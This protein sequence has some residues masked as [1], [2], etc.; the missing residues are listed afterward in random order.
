ML[1]TRIFTS[2]DAA[3]NYYAQGDYYGTESQGTWAGKGSKEL[4]LEGEF[5]AKSNSQFSDL[6]KG[7]MPNGQI[8]AKKTKD[9]EIH[10]PGI[11][12]TFSVPK[13]F[14]IQ[15]LI[16]ANLKEKQAMKT[17]LTKAVN[18]SLDVI[19]KNA[20]VVAR[21]GHA[22]EIKEPISKLIFANFMHTTNRN[23]EPQ[24][25]VHCLL[26]NA[27]KCE[28]GK[29]RSIS[30]DKI[31]KNNKFFGQVF[32][33]ELAIETKKL[34]FEI[35]PTI[36][37][38]GSSS[39]ELSKIDQK[40][41]DGFSTRRQE[42]EELC[43]LYNV[44]T[45]EG[46][47]NIV[48]NSRK[49]KKFV[50]EEEL[51]EAWNTL[52]KKIAQ[53]IELNYL[54]ATN[55]ENNNSKNN[56][57]NENN[58]IK[59]NTDS[60][61]GSKRFFEKAFKGSAAFTQALEFIIKAFSINHN[62]NTEREVVKEAMTEEAYSLKL[63]DLANFCVQDITHYN[64]TFSKEDLYSKTLKFAIGN[65]TFKEIEEVYKL[66]EKNGT[67]LKHKD[68][69]TSKALLLKE[70][71]ILKY[72]KN[73]IGNSKSIIEEKHFTAHFDRF[74]RRELS[75]NSSFKMNEQQ[76]RATK[77]ILASEDKIITVVGLPGVGKSTILNSVRDIAEHKIS[78]IIN[79]SFT[80]E[81]D[82]SGLAP[83]A[84]AAKTLAESAKVESNT[85]HS[86]LGRYQGYCVFSPT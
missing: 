43:K 28:D 11:D 12:L 34:G 18:N 84:S 70:K 71:Q 60:N 54:K 77:Y 10:C 55:N 82:F 13:S 19:E 35:T 9:K 26:A 32:R 46:R 45:K 56:N 86:F 81:S 29:F 59:T 66:Q 30:F 58:D 2:S 27:A 44:T 63:E 69:Y 41:I 52:E 3:T 61:I 4:G 16:Y 33:N 76:K 65:Y 21:K 36:L 42:I 17:A 25:H 64:T 57:N 15:M 50:K 49:S 5:N 23:L 38:D 1:S 39:F 40:L 78:K 14:S 51:T 47:N 72:A 83:T 75:K 8:L 79:M 74:C 85:I 80:K 48:I 7:I 62:K 24:A 22:G 68:L 53:E 20:Y 37:S 6:L 73:S 67:L 31:L